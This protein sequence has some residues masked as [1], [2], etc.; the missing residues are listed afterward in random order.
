[1]AN[2]KRAQDTA[3][4]DDRVVLVTGASRGI[5]KAIA[6]SFA[7]IGSSVVINH[8]GDDVAAD[9]TAK[10]VEEAGGKSFVVK[11]DVSQTA[12]IEEMVAAVYDRWGHVDVL[13]NNAGICPFMDFFEIDVET[14]DRVHHVNLRSAFFLSQVVSK[15]M[16]ESNRSG[17]IISI[18]SISAWVG[19]AQ[20]VHYCPTKAGISALTRSLAIVLGPHGI[21]C[22]AVLPGTI[23]TDLNR[24]DL[25]QE[26]KRQYF[27]TRIPVGRIGKPEDIAGVVRFLASPDA[28]YIN[29]A[30]LLVDGGLFVNLQ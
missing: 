4:A 20:Q 28:K 29:G 19:G 27:E 8:P 22:N 9:E 30:E 11:A 16:I 7:E 18:S 14:W 6:I 21:T 25:S 15:R 24:E 1:M 3:C 26:G 23:E 2:D 5:G 12:E 10:L 13:V 17:Q